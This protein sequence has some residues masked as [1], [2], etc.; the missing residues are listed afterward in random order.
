MIGSNRNILL[1]LPCWL[2]GGIVGFIYQRINCTEN[3]IVDLRV[4]LKGN[5]AIATVMNFVLGFI[6]FGSVFIYPIY[7][8]RFL[9]FTAQMSG[10]MFIP[11]ALLSGMLMPI[12]WW[13]AYRKEHR[14]NL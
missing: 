2:V 5:V 10:A 3:P 4:L 6:L 7:M 8:Q 14:Q 13:Y 11:G 9:G 12:G 1:R